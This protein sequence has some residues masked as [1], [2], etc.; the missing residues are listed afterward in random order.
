MLQNGQSHKNNQICYEIMQCEQNLADIT[1][2]IKRP[3]GKHLI[4][5]IDKNGKFGG[6]LKTIKKMEWKV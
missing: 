5:K 1:N 6:E 3:S 4:L 2:N